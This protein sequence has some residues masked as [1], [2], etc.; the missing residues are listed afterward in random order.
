MRKPGQPAPIVSA[1]AELAL[2]PCDRE[3]SMSSNDR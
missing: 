3:P 1:A 2:D